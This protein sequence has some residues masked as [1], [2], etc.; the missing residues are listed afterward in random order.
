MTPFLAEFIGTALLIILGQGV[1]CNVV[2][3]KTK[4]HNS[5][6]IVISW[7]WAMGVYVG[8]FTA[9]NGSQAHLNP[10]VTLSLAVLKKIAWDEVPTYIAAQLLGAMAGALLT[11]LAF[12]DHYNQTDDANAKLSTFSTRPVFT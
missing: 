1:V 3:Q 9:A 4:G 5:G 6:W 7:G 10:A 8:V 2:L 12:R 11:W